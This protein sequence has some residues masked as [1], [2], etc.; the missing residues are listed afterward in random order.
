MFTLRIIKLKAGG[1]K[2]DYI[3]P[4]GSVSEMQRAAFHHMLGTSYIND[5]E[6]ETFTAICMAHGWILHAINEADKPAAASS[7]A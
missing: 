2:S 7:D 1:Y 6:L 3:R 5:N 4:D